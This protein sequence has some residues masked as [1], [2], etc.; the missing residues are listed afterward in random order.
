MSSATAKPPA[1]IFDMDGL[2]ADSE[3]LHQRAEARLFRRLG[4]DPARVNKGYFGMK[5]EDALRILKTEL[6]FAPSLEEARAAWF[7]AVVEEF[8]QGV[9][10]MPHARQC[11]LELKALG[12]GLGLCSSSPR[13]LVDLALHSMELEGRFQAVVSGDDVTRGKPDPAIYLLAAERL[14]TPPRRCVA[15]EDS[16]AGAQ[17]ALAAGMQCIVIPNGF[18]RAFPFP[19]QVLKLRD[20]SQVTGPV[21][22]SLV[23]FSASPA[24]GRT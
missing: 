15:F 19:L 10:P 24:E 20:L 8:S 3:P 17:A 1:L 11:V 7:A 23:P 21:L 6:G 18:T 2:L 4:L 22:E 12:Y 9:P 5:A 16:P 13:A 14:H